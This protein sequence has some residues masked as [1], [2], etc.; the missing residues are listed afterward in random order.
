MTGGVNGPSSAA[1]LATWGD[2]P[3]GNQGS[4]EIDFT[5]TTYVTAVKLNVA[6]TPDSGVTGITYVNVTAS[7]VPAGPIKPANVVVS[8]A[9]TCGSAPVA[10]TAAYSVIHI[11]GTSYRIEFQIPGGL[12]PGNYFVGINEDGSGDANFVSGNCS[13][14][15]VT[16]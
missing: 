4:Y 6:T 14:L 15:I 1:A 16:S 12:T 8:L 5:G 10:L 11:L 3:E 13:G 9:T 7:G 2:D